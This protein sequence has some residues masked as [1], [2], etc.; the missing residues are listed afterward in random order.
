VALDAS[1]A[2]CDL[3]I[4]LS[5]G[6]LESLSTEYKQGEGFAWQLNGDPGHLVAS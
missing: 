5:G 1:D 2:S 6:L 4:H 3:N